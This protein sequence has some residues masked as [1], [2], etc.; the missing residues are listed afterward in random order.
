[1]VGHGIGNLDLTATAPASVDPA[2]FDPTSAS[3]VIGLNLGFALKSCSHR[4]KLYDDLASVGTVSLVLGELSAGQTLGEAVDVLEQFPDR[5]R[6]AFDGDDFC[7]LHGREPNGSAGGQFQWR[8]VSGRK[9]PD[10][11]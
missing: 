7:Y 3:F 9:Q 2:T 5:F 10:T 1:V 11:I 8:P 6:I 4:A